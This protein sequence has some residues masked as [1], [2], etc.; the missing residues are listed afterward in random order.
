MRTIFGSRPTWASAATADVTS[1]PTTLGTWTC[2]T[3][4]ETVSVTVEPGAILEPPPGFSSET[5]PDGTV[6]LGATTTRGTSPAFLIWVTARGRAGGR[7]SGTATGLFVFD[8]LW[9]CLGR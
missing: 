1:W 5:C 8:R 7:T 3:P 9:Y 4:L 6:S 2:G